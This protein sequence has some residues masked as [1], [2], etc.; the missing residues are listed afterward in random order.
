MPGF[1]RT[2]F[3]LKSK[4]KVVVPKFRNANEYSQWMHDTHGTPLPQKMK[5]ANE[6]A[7]KR[8]IQEEERRQ[9]IMDNARE[10]Q[11]QKKANSTKPPKTN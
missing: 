1:F 9:I 4:P 11:A 8:L 5:E 10:R 3:G 2:L 6:A 7:K